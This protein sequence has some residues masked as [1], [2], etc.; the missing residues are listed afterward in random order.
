MNAF[1]Q[2]RLD[3]LVEALRRGFTE[4]LGLKAAALAAS[5]G[6]FMIVRGTDE[7]RQMSILV[8][9]AALL[10]SDSSSRMLVS[11]IPRQVRVTL[12]GSRSVLNAARRDGLAA[13]QMDL[14]EADD[15]D[16]HFFYFN[17][18]E[19]EVPAGT[20]IVQIAPAAVP[21][22][23][24]ERIQREVRVEPNLK[25][26][27]REGTVL[28]SAAVRPARIRVRGAAAEVQRLE[29]VLTG[30]IDLGTLP[31]GRNNTRVQLN[32]PPEHVQYLDEAMVVVTLT[33][34]PQMSRS[35]FRDRAV[36]VEG[37]SNV[38]TRPPR[39]HVILSGPSAQVERVEEDQL[40]P[41]VTL[42]EAPESDLTLPVEL[43]GVPSGLTVEIDPP[44]VVIPVR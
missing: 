7:E 9:V 31:V 25:G 33:T 14:R 19:F 41:Y 21:L 44:E 2:G 24:V 30:P 37:V 34:E 29:R 40:I 42:S 11:E 38:I 32:P 4:D 18:D 8:D 23:W 27:V 36:Q 28:V 10:P 35:V 6:L 3:A 1:W 16:E 26:E 13:I 15:A 12:R 20:S 39:V 43:R 5:L 17:Q 22:T